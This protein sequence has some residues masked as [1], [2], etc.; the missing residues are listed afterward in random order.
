MTTFSNAVAGAQLMVTSP[1]STPDG[2]QVLGDGTIRGPVF[3]SGRYVKYILMLSG[4]QNNR[5]RSAILWVRSGEYGPTSAADF[6]S[7]SRMFYTE[8]FFTGM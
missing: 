1:N 8:L 4:A 6:M 3:Y 2:N 7:S 5:L